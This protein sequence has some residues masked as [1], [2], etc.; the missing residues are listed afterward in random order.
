MNTPV[1]EFRNVDYQPASCTRGALRQVSFSVRSG[2]LVLIGLEDMEPNPILDAAAGLLD[3][4]GGSVLFCGQDWTHV[5]DSD[6]GSRRHGIGRVFEPG[7]WIS[8]LTVTENVKLAT[9]HHTNR[10]EV[11][12][13]DEAA[14][15]A[16]LAGLPSIPDAYPGDVRRDTLRRT[17]WV[18]A[19]M[20]HP[21]LVLLEK[22][23]TDLPPVAVENLLTM[24]RGALH[25]GSAVVWTSVDTG[26]WSKTQGPDTQRY[27]VHNGTLVTHE[28]PH[29]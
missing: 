15:L 13:E 7:G 24:V 10:S 29:G 28:A 1:L 23:M 14:R 12:I 11:D 19:F 5:S 27:R 16:S 3:L 4:D 22:P 8:N 18:R 17:Q 25:A 21:R 6:L 9:R 2:G 26:F 20:G